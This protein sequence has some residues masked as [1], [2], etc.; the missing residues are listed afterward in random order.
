MAALPELEVVQ[1][2][3]DGIDPRTGELLTTPRNLRADEARLRYL[4]ALQALAKRSPGEHSGAPSHFGA[5]WL[6]EDDARLQERWSEPAAPS[7][8]VL[9]IDFGRT[10]GSIVARLVHLGVYPDRDA[11]RIANEKR[12]QKAPQGAG[13]AT[14]PVAAE[15]IEVRTPVAA[16]EVPDPFIAEPAMP[17][18]PP[19]KVQ[20]PEKRDPFVL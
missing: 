10:P 6:P 1:M 9:S 2:L 16:Q 5:R 20:A 17:P 18:M 19:P 3:C 14:P 12:G 15:A 13:V 11:A 7:A 4:K 8:E